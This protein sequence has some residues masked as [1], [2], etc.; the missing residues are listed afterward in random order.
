MECLDSKKKNIK[1]KNFSPFAA[2]TITIYEIRI[3]FSLNI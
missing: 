1:H 3:V 2:N